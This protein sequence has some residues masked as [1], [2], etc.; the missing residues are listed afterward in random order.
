[1]D[2][3]AVWRLRVSAAVRTVGWYVRSE[4][5]MLSKLFLV[6]IVA[7]ICADA[8]MTSTHPARADVAMSDGERLK[9]LWDAD[10]EFY[11]SKEFESNFNDLINAGE[12]VHNQDAVH[13]LYYR[14]W[15]LGV[16]FGMEYENGLLLA[17]K[18]RKLFC[19]PEKLVLT[20]DQIISI[21]DT[22]ISHNKNR[23]PPSY[24]MDQFTGDAFVELFPCHEP[25]P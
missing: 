22:F 12:Y 17:N 4:M 19:V 8:A 13:K 14:G 2:A 15:I 3:R 18:Q 5:A 16:Y 6:A 11:N 9:A 25:P 1:M 21:V 23:Y 7:S 10:K 20:E 24:S